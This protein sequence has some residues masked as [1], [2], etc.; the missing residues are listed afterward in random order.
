MGYPLALSTNIRQGLAGTNTLAF[1]RK[2]TNCG[3]KKFYRIGPKGWGLVSWLQVDAQDQ[4]SSGKNILATRGQMFV[5][6]Y[7]SVIY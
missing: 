1:L 7:L 3:R 5:K 2:S 6:L 4:N